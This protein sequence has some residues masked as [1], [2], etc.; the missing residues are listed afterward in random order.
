LTAPGRVRAWLGAPR[1]GFH[2]PRH[3]VRLRLT[4]LYGSLF[5]ISGAVLLTITYLLVRHSTGGSVIAIDRISGSVTGATGATGLPGPVSVFGGPTGAGGIEVSGPGSKTGF[6]GSPVAIATLKAAQSQI[7]QVVSLARAQP[8]NELH[9]LLTQS[10]VALAVMT[11]VSIGLGWLVA[12][13]VLRPLRTIT[14]AARDISATDLHRRLALEGP[15][16]ELRELG[17][18]FDG[19]LGRLEAAFVAQRQFV[20]NASHELRTPLARQ[21]TVA[22]VALGDPDATVESLRRS[23]ERVLA[24]GEQQ[25][26]L[27]EALLTLA[28]SERGL[29]QREPFDLAALTRIVLAGRTAELEQGGLRLETTLDAAPAS[30]EPRLAERLVANLVDNAIRHNRP[31]GSVRVATRTT[32]GLATISVANTGPVVPPGELDRLFEPFQRLDGERTASRDGMGLGLS[33]AE[34]IARAHGGRL[35]AWPQA[36]GG[37][38]VEAIFPS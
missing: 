21:R 36:G 11:V 13:R 31:H 29:A 23:H 5:L 25:E 10:A 4:A 6:P 12:G 8:G 7:Q 15:N 9:A 18:T 35:T 30:G 27:I 37:L 3:T 34:A 16:D 24:A 20:A 32:D 26:R 19:L 33:I 22:E 38:I 1:R 14:M 17:S 2:L 28:R